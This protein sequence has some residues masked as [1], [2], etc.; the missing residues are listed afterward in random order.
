MNKIS[1]KEVVKHWKSLLR[2]EVES[3]DLE[4]FK[5]HVDVAL[6]DINSG[7]GGDSFMVGLGDF[8]GLFQPE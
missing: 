5:E 2:E 7:H 4:I 8:K 1:S 3:P 6:K